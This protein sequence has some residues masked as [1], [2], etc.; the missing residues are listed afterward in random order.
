MDLKDID[1]YHFQSKVERDLANFVLGAK[2]NESFVYG[3]SKHSMSYTLLRLA[4]EFFTQGL[5]HLVQK[6]VGT[7]LHYVAVKRKGR[8]KR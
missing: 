4:H 3:T 1:T 8:N 6:R 7:E 5:V 2:P